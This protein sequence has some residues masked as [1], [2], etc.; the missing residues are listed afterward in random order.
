VIKLKHFFIIGAQRAGTTSLAKILDAHPQI[1]MAKPFKPEAKYFLN[2]DR[3]NLNYNEYLKLFFSKRSNEKLL[4]EKTTAYLDNDIFVGKKIKKIISNF[5]CIIILRDPIIRAFSHYKFSKRNALED[6]NF[7]KAIKLE[8]IRSKNYNSS[9]NKKISSNPF[10]YVERG[11]YYKYI[12]Q[13]EKLLKKKNII[14]LIF[15]NFFQDLNYIKMLYK[16]LGV[17][18]NFAPRNFNIKYNNSNHKQTNLEKLKIINVLKKEFKK[19]NT[20][21]AKRYKLD[22]SKWIF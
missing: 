6:L 1:N 10:A 20:L 13:W 18:E 5:K 3:A 16:K 7:T 12:L 14:I 2:T 22:L 9:I 21:L 19:S 8:K 17:N 15:E 4:G 11:K